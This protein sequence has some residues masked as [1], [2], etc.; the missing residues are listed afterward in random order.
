MVFLESIMLRFRKSSKVRRNITI[1]ESSL[2]LFSEGARYWSTF[3]PL[4][5]ELIAREI[6]FR[7]FT[8]DLYDPALKIDSDYMLSRRLSNNSF[9]LQKINWL[10][11]P[12]LVATTPN[13]G[14][15]GYPIQKSPHVGRLVHLFHHIGDIGI[16]K[17][18]SLD[19]YDDVV[20]IGEFQA[21]SIRYLE[22]LRNLKKKNLVALGLPYMDVLARSKSSVSPTS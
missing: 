22:D 14:V 4:I 12:C 11:T 5:Q 3:E 8:L 17:K 21:R 15:P 7:F 9:G 16:Y 1:D 20:M 2:V 18:H 19:H 13:I 6:P 10:R